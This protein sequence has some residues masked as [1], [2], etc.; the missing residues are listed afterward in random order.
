MATAGLHGE[1][2]PQ[3][4]VGLRL[5]LAHRRDATC[6]ELGHVER[7]VRAD[8]QVRRAGEAGGEAGALPGE[9]VD[10]VDGP[11]CARARVLGTARERGHVE[12]AVRALLDIGGHLLEG[13]RRPDHA[14]GQTVHRGHRPRDPDGLGRQHGEG[15]DPAVVVHLQ[16]RV[17]A[18]VRD[19]PVVAPLRDG[20]GVGVLDPGVAG[21]HADLRE[22]VRLAASGVVDPVV[23]VAVGVVPLLV[24]GQGEPLRADV[25]PA[26]GQPR[27]A[28]L[29]VRRGPRN[30]PPRAVERDTGDIG[31]RPPGL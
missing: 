4:H 7:A 19:H 13:V 14:G 27:R 29:E 28:R 30:G 22:R 18:G 17:G 12:H 26:Q 10:P 6:E 24:V 9:G 23:D 11:P 21:L 31:H 5:A 2:S 20:V 16:Q 25:G 8:R 1:R 15:G 3:V